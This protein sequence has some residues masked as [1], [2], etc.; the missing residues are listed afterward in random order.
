MTCSDSIGQPGLLERPNELSRASLLPLAAGSAG[1]GSV[2]LGAIDDDFDASPSAEAPPNGA[3]HPRTPREQAPAPEAEEISLAKR[4]SY[5]LQ[6]PLEAYLAKQGAVEWPHSFFPY[7]RDGIRALVNRDVLLLADDMGLGKT[8]QA[9]A[10]IR[11]LFRLGRIDSALLVVPASLIVQWRRELR[12]WAPDLRTSTVRGPTSQRAFQWRAPAHVYI[13]TYETLRSDFT[14]NPMSPPRRRTWGVVI[15]DEAQKIKNREVELSRICKRL[16]RAR[17]WALTGTPLENRI[18]DLASICEFLTPWTDGDDL[19]HLTPGQ[20]LLDRHQELQLRRRKQDVLTELPPKTVIELSLELSPRQKETYL[21][22]ERE[23][24]VRLRELGTEVR[25]THVL[26]LITRLKQICNICPTSGE[27]TKLDDIEERLDALVDTEH[28]AL[29]F[30][31]YTEQYGVKEVVERLARFS[32]ISYTGALSSTARDRAISS[33]RTDERHKALVLSLRAGGQGL[34]LQEASYVFHFDHWWNPAVERQA[35]DRSHRLGQTSPVTVYKY[36]CEDTIEQRIDAIL[37]EKQALFDQLVDDVSIDLT[38]HLTAAE[39]FGLFGLEAPPTGRRAE[40]PRY[41]GMTGE[42][43]ERHLRD[44]LVLLDWSVELTRR[45]RDGGIDLIATKVDR[46]GIET[47]LYV[48][49][50]NQAA[51]VSVETVRELNGVLDPTVQGVVASPSGFTA[52]AR[53]FADARGIQLWDADH[54]AAL[55]QQARD[56]A[57]PPDAEDHDEGE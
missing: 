14:E 9:A 2:P 41:G 27:S 49:C 45:S 15:L 34:N 42:E 46:V 48:Q 31:Q 37:H 40:P 38:K 23:G 20:D 50:K 28:R 55:T 7:Q 36:V 33:F 10:A 19:L 22:A 26:E 21:R 1:G 11:I 52:D 17:A 25:I 3:T 18:D 16:P 32:P 29:I 30:S 5:L 54:L 24:I 4:L 44:L 53:A 56:A 43:F 8:I 57:T 12:L 35:E 51:P 39:L 6:P 13:T 47:K